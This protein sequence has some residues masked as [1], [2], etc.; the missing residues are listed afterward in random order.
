MSSPE[1]YKPDPLSASTEWDQISEQQLDD[2]LSRA[3]TLAGNLAQEVSDSNSLQ[4]A[5]NLP[6]SI[7]LRDADS[8]IEELDKLLAE[9]KRQIESVEANGTHVE[10][11]SDHAPSIETPQHQ[12]L[13]RQATVV[14]DF[15]SE[16]TRPEEP[17][18]TSIAPEPPTSAPHGGFNAAVTAPN[19]VVTAATEVTGKKRAAAAPA[20]DDSADL[21]TQIADTPTR[22]GKR[23]MH[24][25]TD[26][27]SP[28]ATRVCD[29]GIRVLEAMDKP[30]ARINPKVKS[31]LGW[32]GLVFFASAVV[33]LCLAHR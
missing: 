9:T 18:S 31:I 4:A 1:G 5:A 17:A 6:N 24:I 20:L 15:M 13:T 8:E 19:A 3:S 30:L 33:V 22:A 27:V 12:S 28:A 23:K 11:F 26:R 14:P 25:L 21:S 16:F 29:S 7:E 10:D 32:V 2:A